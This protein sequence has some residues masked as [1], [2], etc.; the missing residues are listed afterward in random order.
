M[1]RAR[2]RRRRRDLFALAS[3]PVAAP[4]WLALVLGAATVAAM[5]SRCDPSSARL[6]EAL[7]AADAPPVV[8]AASLPQGRTAVRVQPRDAA[9]AALVRSIALDEW[10]EHA[11]VGDPIDVVLDAD[12]L[13][14][15]AQARI[16]WEVLV[17]DIDAL[18]AQERARLHQPQAQRPADWY[19]E[20]HDFG[21]ITSHLEA[22]AAEMPERVRLQVVGGSVEGRPIHA[23][24]LG[25][26]EGGVPM[27]INGAQHAREWIAAAVPICVAERLARGQDDPALQGLLDRTALWV[28][29]VVN[30]D[31]YQY[32]WGSDR[33]WRKNRRGG[34]GVDLNRNWGVAFGGAGSSG[35]RRSQIYRGEYAFS[36]PET[37][38]LRDLVRR[39]HIAVHIDFHSY[40]QLLLHPWSYTAAPPRDRDRYAAIADRLAS[41]IYAAH[42]E[43]YEIMPGA[44]LYAAAGTMTDWVYGDGGATSF[45]IELRPRGGSGFVLPPEQIRP[46]CDEA[47]AAVLELR[48]TAAP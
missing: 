40:G 18:A 34:H 17:A 37:A 29:P 11:G 23:L 28:V 24:V 45:T 5:L 7:P 35:N 42:G 14:A 22:L 36:E 13:V 12:G 20:Y 44:R 39:E 47:M 25:N 43:R 8:A 10:S 26:H 21:A 38:A 48:R 9:E 2:R 32:S 19:A 16:P 3:A 33:Y 15:L 6:D 1:P 46:T 4:R 31:G 30:P 27:L 41:A